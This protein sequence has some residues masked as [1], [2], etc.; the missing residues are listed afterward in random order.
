MALKKSALKFRADVSPL[1][2]L[3]YANDESD[4]QNLIQPLVP[5]VSESP[6]PVIPKNYI[7]VILHKKK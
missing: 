1:E 4:E 7:F 6:G 5:Y 3:D 2:V